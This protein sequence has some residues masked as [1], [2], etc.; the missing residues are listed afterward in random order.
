M[1]TGV[2]NK[3]SVKSLEEL[4]KLRE[5][6]KKKVTLR[7]DGEGD[8][9][10]L[11]VGMATCGIAAGARTTLS[12]LLD[13]IQKQNIENI[14]IIQVGCLGYCHSEPIVQVNEP[15]K[16]PIIYGNVDDKR[17]R[18]IINKHIINHELIDDAI[19]IETYK[20]P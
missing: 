20:K 18:E 10:E 5:E 9:I 14:K 3:V 7:K 12:A 6:S 8:Y 1:N 11:M 16:E 2:V 19:I 17:A 4:K 13:E 15:G